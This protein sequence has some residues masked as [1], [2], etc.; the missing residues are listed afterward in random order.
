M[1][2]FYGTETKYVDVTYICHKKL[3][4]NNILTIP[5]SE[6]ERAKIFG[7]PIYGVL[8]HIKIDNKIYTHEEEIVMDFPAINNLFFIRQNWWDTEGKYIQPVEER[9]ARLHEFIYL[10]YGNIREE[11]PEQLMAMKFIRE[12]DTVLEIGGNIGRNS[13]II[14][15]ILNDEKRLVVL[16]SCEKYANQL[17]E[18][19]DEN[20]FN[21]QIEA[22]ALSK[23][24]LIQKDWNTY[25]S[26]TVP[27]G[28]TKVNTITFEK[29][30]EK[31]SL[32]FNVLVLDCEGAIY[33]ILK[34]EPNLL[35]GI[36]TIIIENDFFEN[37][38]KDFV[39]N[40]FKE[41]GFH[42]VWNQAGGWGPCSH[43][44]YQ[45]YQK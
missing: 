2:V 33:Q 40:I 13:C 16:E 34:D 38:K 35:N 29:L 19:R 43:C 41:N 5:K 9:L 15:N 30:L 12:N 7:D 21:F 26:E 11:Y 3:V 45:V 4:K 23:V 17:K 24:P 14:A 6:Y 22:S 10:N 32:K 8:K 31:Y 44:F 25:V 39:H 1:K 18:N 28:Y 27:I 37:D 42:V 20:Y 36:E